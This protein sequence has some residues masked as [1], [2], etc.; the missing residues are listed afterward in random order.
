MIE[1][2]KGLILIRYGSMVFGKYVIWKEIT[3]GFY[4]SI[5]IPKILSGFERV[6][7]ECLV[8]RRMTLL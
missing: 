4:L 5:K 3:L 8:E 2:L 1:T 7:W 6:S